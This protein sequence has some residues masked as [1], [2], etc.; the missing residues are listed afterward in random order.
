MKKIHSFIVLFLLL[1]SVLSIAK[2][3][4][5]TVKA[6]GE[7]DVV[8]LR[9]QRP[10]LFVDQGVSIDLTAINY[11][12]ALG[13]V[14]LSDGTISETSSGLSYAGTTL[15]ATEK[16]IHTFLFS[17]GEENVRIYV[18]AKNPEET[19]YIIYE[20]NFTSLP[21]GPLPSDYALVKGVAG[22]ENGYLY[23]DSPATGSPS[24]VTLPGYLRGFKNYIIETDFSILSAVEPSRWASV[25]FRFSLDNYFQMA[26]RQNAMAANGVEFAKAING[27]WNVPITTSYTEAINPA[28]IY[29]LKIDLFGSVVNEY[30]ND[31]LMITYENANDY[32][33]GLIGFQSSGSKAIYN[34]IVITMPES[35]I[36]NTTVDYSAIPTLY[37]PESNVITPPGAI[38]MID[39]VEDLEAL[40]DEV[41]PQTVVLRINANLD[42][43]APSGVAIMPIQDVF[44]YVNERVI[45]AFYTKNR[46]VAVG[47]ASLLKTYGV[48]DVFLISPNDDAIIAAREEYNM[49]RCVFEVTYNSAKPV[50]TDED[51]LLIRDMTNSTGAIV[52]KLPIEYT[53]QY[54]VFY[55][56]KRLVSVWSDTFGKEFPMVVKALVTGVNG[57]VVED[58][59][60][61][62]AQ[63][64][65]F[66]E[67]TLLRRPISIGHRGLPYLAPENS[68][69]SM[70][71]AIE[72][73]A[74]VVELDI[75]LTTDNEIV[76][77]HD[78]T[79]TRTTGQ[80]LIVEEST[81]A[82]LRALEL[83]DTFGI[84]ETMRIP[85]LNEF[86]ERI[87]G[88]DTILFIEIKSSNPDIITRLKELI[89]E[90]DVSSQ[91]VVIS[92][93]ANQLT[94]MSVVLPE[95]SKGYL[96]TAL[97]NATNLE[98][99]IRATLN[100]VVPIQT[101]I[102][103]EY[104]QLTSEFVVQMNYR[105]LSIWPWTMNTSDAFYQT[106]M[107][108][109]G[110]LTTNYSDILENTFNRFKINENEI[111]LDLYAPI[112]YSIRG[113]ISMQNGTNY[114]YIPVLQ[115]LSGTETGI[116][117]DQLS[118]I[119]SFTTVGDAYLLAS[120][121]S[122]LPNGQAFTIYSELIHV[123]VIDTTPEIEDPI[124]DPIDDDPIDDPVDDDPI[125]DPADD[126]PGD[127][128][129]VE[130]NNP[131]GWIIGGITGGVTFITGAIFLGLRFFKK[132]KI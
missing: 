19:E 53:N 21:D 125:D 29:R 70:N 104:S 41:R 1:F 13:E 46:D 60:A 68:M 96:S 45:P 27:N 103:P 52:A 23:L 95:I 40:A 113:K 78:G 101:T 32:T 35:Y 20:K 37:T 73:K 82:Q 112:Q 24:Q 111:T 109:V 58:I 119:T 26:I 17:V 64:L 7:E 55:L 130:E 4:N 65:A 93:N 114:N 43:T 74:D 34:N 66:P 80:A 102:N 57:I 107:Y 126:D 39:S 110:G 100:A 87:L 8:L 85:T 3:Q 117:L 48:R 127:D 42:V 77:I 115:V 15:S 12:S 123:S 76:V 54:N 120:F 72:A 49:I 50:L 116:V 44:Q 67:N 97:L 99:S 83:T 18:F 2:F 81:L 14:A 22:V 91:I 94:Q 118:N 75:Y 92:F 122:Y 61:Y 47:I 98:S 132:P 89:D 69:P 25:M 86:F 62:Y 124:D 51:L 131:L 108:G 88:E 30:I 16:G 59:D 63:L 121:T 79:T 11:N 9:E 106:Y 31:T 6:E 36:D 105:G 5:F 10:Y 56:Q 129:P 28:A 33:N 128:D 71:L 90:Y 38:K 84:E